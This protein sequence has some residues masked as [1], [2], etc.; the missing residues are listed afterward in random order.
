MANRRRDFRSFCGAT[1]R[2]RNVQQQPMVGR[3]GVV[4]ITLT[5]QR[6]DKTRRGDAC[7]RPETLK[8]Q[9]GQH[10]REGERERERG[11]MRALDNA[12]IYSGFVYLRFLFMFGRRQFSWRRQW[13]QLGFAFAFGFGLNRD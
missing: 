10:G 1:E 3:T 8:R 2:I 12:V 13:P 5:Q 7:N 11:E 6:R 4:A 9:V